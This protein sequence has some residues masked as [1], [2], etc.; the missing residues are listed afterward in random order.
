MT[1]LAAVS[2][3]RLL[4]R[5]AALQLALDNGTACRP[6]A[7]AELLETDA[8]LARIEEGKFGRCDGCGGAIGRQRLLA[9]PAARLC[10]EC[11]SK[12]RVAG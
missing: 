9:L 4:K 6:T 3:E 2:K 8:A 5:R 11:T 1:A 12:M 10:I 7:T